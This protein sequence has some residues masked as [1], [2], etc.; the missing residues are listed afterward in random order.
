MV[1]GLVGPD[2]RSSVPNGI[3]DMAAAAEDLVLDERVEAELHNMWEGAMDFR[4]LTATYKLEIVFTENRSMHNP[5]GGFIYALTNGGYM[6][7][8]GDE[9]VYF[10]TNKVPRISGTGDKA[11]NN[12]LKPEWIGTDAAVCPKC[13]SA[14]KP[15]E[16]MGQVYAKITTQ[17]WTSLA[18]GM[19]R[20]LNY[21]AD[22][23]VGHFKG[24]FR[25]ASTIENSERA[26]AAYNAVRME[27]QWVVYPLQ[28]ILKDTQNGAELKGRI[29]A[30]LSA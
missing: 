23:R 7:G 13:R 3:Y 25:I 8:G 19:F 4:E 20:A 18:L 16:L 27:R 17:N 6:H 5:Y 1:A 24:D 10:C 30:F 15:K 2:G 28:N 12:P 21:D 11:C 29:R 26:D 14:I 22:I 9:G